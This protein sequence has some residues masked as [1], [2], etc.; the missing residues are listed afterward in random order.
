MFASCRPKTTG[1]IVQR[2]KSQTVSGV[3]PKQFKKVRVS[4]G[5]AVI[6]H[7]EEGQQQCEKLVVL[8]RQEVERIEYWESLLSAFDSETPAHGM[9]PLRFRVCLCPPVKSFWK[10]I[11]KIQ[12]G[13]YPLGD[14]KS[15]VDGEDC[16]S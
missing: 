14:S 1:D 13:V 8:S 11:Q 6:M 9:V 12:L 16:I 10:H 4:F 2:P 3:D 5:D 15:Q 7:G